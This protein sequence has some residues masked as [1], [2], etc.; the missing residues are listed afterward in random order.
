MILESLLHGGR[1]RTAPAASISNQTEPTAPA[2]PRDQM[3]RSRGSSPIGA[4]HALA[5]CPATRSSSGSSRRPFERPVCPSS[6]ALATRCSV[7][8]TLPPRLVWS[9][10]A[11]TTCLASSLSSYPASSLRLC[12]PHS[13]VVSNGHRITWAL[14]QTPT[15][16]FYP[17]SR[18]ATMEGRMRAPR[19]SRMCHT[20]A[21]ASICTSVAPLGSSTCLPLP[22]YL[23]YPLAERLRRWFA[24]S[25]ERSDRV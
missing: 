1:S 18:N 19:A 16:P 7:S 11:S 12:P 23:I 14:W 2:A 17:R 9:L 8:A 5:L 24:S 25:T 13:S 20:S 3:D 15:H 21:L 4:S 10:V 22:T 6:A